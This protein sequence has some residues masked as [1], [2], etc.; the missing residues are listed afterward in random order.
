MS[1]KE[2]SLQ[3]GSGNINLADLKGDISIQTGSGN[4]SGDSL[5]GNV[6]ASS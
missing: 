6:S 2:I 4:I 3:A 5:S 1:V